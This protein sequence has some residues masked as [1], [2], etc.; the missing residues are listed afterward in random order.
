[1]NNNGPE[2]VEDL[3]EEKDINFSINNEEDEVDS[4]SDIQKYNISNIYDD[5]IYDIKELNIN[6][7]NLNSENKIEFKHHW[8]NCS[9]I[10]K[11]LINDR[12]PIKRKKDY[13]DD[14][15]DELV[16]FKSKDKRSPSK[17]KKRLFYH[18]KNK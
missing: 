7:N 6:N 5:L 1:M 9:K 17:K 12:K 3:D 11:L 8:S 15:N 18:K 4:D 2:D 16:D 13:E 14:D 10:D